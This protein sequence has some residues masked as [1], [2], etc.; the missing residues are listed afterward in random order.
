MSLRKWV[1]Q[2][3]Y[4]YAAEKTGFILN[5]KRRDGS[6]SRYA[7]LDDV[8]EDL[9]FYMQLIKFGMGRCTWDAAQ[10]IRSGKLERD[11]G[12]ALVK[13]YDQERPKEYLNEILEYLEMD[14]DEFED[15]IDSFRPHHLWTEDE[16]G[17]FRLTT[18]IN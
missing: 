14:L 12:I 16:A 13:K 15:V 1:P 5:P 7:G 4:Y 8:M 17:K 9:H 10:E 6:Y 3:N 2:E 11:E 18:T